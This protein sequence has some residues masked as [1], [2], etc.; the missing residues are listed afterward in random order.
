MS[1]GSRLNKG[2]GFLL[3]VPA[4]DIAE[5]GAGG[6]SIVSRRRRRAR[7]M[8]ARGAPA[9][10]PARSATTTAA[11]SATLTDANVVLGYLHAERLPS[12]AARSTRSG[13]RGRS[14]SRSRAPLGLPLDE[15]AH[16]VH[17]VGCA[18]MARAVRA[19]TVERGRDPRDFTLFAF[20]GNGPLFAAEMAAVARDRH[21]SSCRPR[22]GVFSA[23]GLLEAEVEHHLVRTFL[24][25]LDGLDAAEI[26][27]PL[28]ARWRRGRGAA[29]RRGPPAR[30]LE[31]ARSV[32]LPAT[33][34]SRSS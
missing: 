16:G 4:I 7:C 28:R 33:R 12:G 11:P 19:V 21:A 20:G 15:A 23:F 14:P 32:D 13:A 3:R 22:P 31:L 34:A 29:A 17:L 24:R 9:P 6:G 25:P 10:C 30:R 27:A 1:Q 26:D 18:G 5:V 8:S 2:G